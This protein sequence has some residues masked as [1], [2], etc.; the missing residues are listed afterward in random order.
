MVRKIDGLVKAKPDIIVMTGDTFAV[1]KA[2]AAT[3][4]KNPALAAVPA[5]KNLSIYNLPFYADSSVI[6]YPTIL[7]QWTDA[8]SN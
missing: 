7:R 2:L 5:I 8:L 3:V 1:Q 6:E 4:K